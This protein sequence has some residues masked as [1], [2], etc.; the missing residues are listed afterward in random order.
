MSWQNHAG[1]VQGEEAQA[2][3]NGRQRG[4]NSMSQPPGV[5]PVLPVGRGANPE[6]G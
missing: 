2:V 5:K 1:T 3:E 6:R 4:E